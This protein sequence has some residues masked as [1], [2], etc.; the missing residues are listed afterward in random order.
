MADRRIFSGIQP[1][2]ELHLGNWV[3]AVRNW[4]DLAQGNECIYCIVDYHALTL[5]RSGDEL[6][7]DSRAMA[8]S[9]LAAG[10]DPE[11]CTLFLQSDV[12]EHVELAWILATVAPMGE[13][14][15]MTQY[16]DKVGRGLT[17]DLGLFAYPVLQAADILL[18]K[19]EAVPVGEDQVQHL[20]LTR[21]VARRFNN[22]YGDVFP[23]PEVLLTEVPRVSGL[24]GKG[25]MS[26]SAGNHLPLF[27]DAADTAK[28]VGAA[29]TDPARVRRDD[30]GDPDNC[31]L[32]PLHRAFLD[33]EARAPLAAGCRSAEIGC[34]QCKGALVEGLE[35][36]LAPMRDAHASL[37]DDSVD[38]VLEAG[39]AA[40]R[41]TAGEVID[42]VRSVTGLGRG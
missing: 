20:E 34:V 8:K 36:S 24:D 1:T 26:K 11:A 42:E 38:G 6:R 39:A 30:P 41:E 5:H 21:E 32:W 9:L 29:V 23:E 33:E 19:A 14:N 2:G 40:A 35:A 37:D 15:R 3:G 4:V 7:A 16:K 27:T 25:K 13:L 17:P 12:P 18:Y 22:L 10:V 28:R 31:N